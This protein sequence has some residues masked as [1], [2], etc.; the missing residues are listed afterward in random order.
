MREAGCPL[1]TLIAVNS[2]SRDEVAMRCFYVLVHGRLR[3]LTELTELDEDVE[4]PAGFL[5]HRFVLA[6]NP[7]EAMRKAFK[8][9]SSNL[10]RQ[11]G[12]LRNHTAELKLEA[13]EVTT[14]SLINAFLPANRGHTF[15]ERE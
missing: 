14:A 4:Q 12:W 7:N 2:K 5:C 15:Y 8:S 11:T 9:V 3:W 10:D 1:P 6:S 13:E